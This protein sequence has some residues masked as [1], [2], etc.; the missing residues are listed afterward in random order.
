M[1]LEKSKTRTHPSPPHS[2]YPNFLKSH[3]TCYQSLFDF[4]RL[5][6]TEIF[7]MKSVITCPTTPTKNL[8]TSYFLLLWNHQFLLVIGKRDREREKDRKEKI[9]QYL[10]ISLI[11][12]LIL[13]R[14]KKKM[15]K[16]TSS[17]TCRPPHTP[18]TT[19]TVPV[20]STPPWCFSR[21][22]Y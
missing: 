2:S 3:G 14:K 17:T 18:T 10:S 7:F 13:H 11:F 6:G 1:W 8:T 21:K 20:F 9:D 4:S 15:K 16:T 22:S 12:S 5:Y 19:K